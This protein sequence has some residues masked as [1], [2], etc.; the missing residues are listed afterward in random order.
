[1]IVRKL[2]IEDLPTRVKWMN[3]PRIYSSMHYEIP[4]LLEKTQEW[5]YNNQYKDNRLDVVICDSSDNNSIVAFAGFVG[6]DT[7]I[8]KAETYLFVDPDRIGEGLGSKA[9]SLMIDY[10][11]N[12]LQLNKLYVITNEDNYSSIRIQEKFGYK[13]E[14][15]FREEYKSVDGS[16]KDRLYYGLLKK[17]WVDE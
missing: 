14:G 12:V 17:D 13:L 6:V 1:M 3:N 16:L 15:R 8:G 4:I 10:A 9:K 2:D 7:V 11:F 5:F